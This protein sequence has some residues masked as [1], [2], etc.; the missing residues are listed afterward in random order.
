MPDFKIFAIVYSP[1]RQPKIAEFTNI[2]GKTYVISRF[3]DDK[4]L[5]AIS[6]KG[7]IPP[8]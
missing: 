3:L 8:N 7:P 5:V 1:Y 4:L 6:P 2:A